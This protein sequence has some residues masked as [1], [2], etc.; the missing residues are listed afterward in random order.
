MKK[1]VSVAIKDFVDSTTT[2]CHNL[3]ITN[4]KNTSFDVISHKW[5]QGNGIENV[6]YTNFKCK[7]ISELS[8]LIILDLNVNEVKKKNVEVF[9]NRRSSRVFK[10]RKKAVEFFTKVSR[11]IVDELT[12]TN[13]TRV[14]AK[15]IDLSTYLSN[16]TPDEK[17]K[18]ME[19]KHIKIK[20]Q[21]NNFTLKKIDKISKRLK[22]IEESRKIKRGN[23]FKVIKIRNIEKIS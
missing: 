14:A 5:T 17:L 21:T 19:S 12:I 23:N 6:E 8:K 3:V 10:Y 11:Y 1:S 2:I 7:D 13:P 9:R 16:I 18:I 4:V 15:T 22:Q 20:S